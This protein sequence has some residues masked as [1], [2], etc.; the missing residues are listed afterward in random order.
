MKRSTASLFKAGP[1]TSLLRSIVNRNSG[2]GGRKP[3]D[4]R[5]GREVIQLEYAVHEYTIILVKNYL[6][7]TTA[8]QIRELFETHGALARLLVPPGGT[9]AI[10]EFARADEASSAFR[11]VVYRRLRRRGMGMG[12]NR[13]VGHTSAAGLPDEHR[14]KIAEQAAGDEGEDEELPSPLGAETK[15]FFKT[16]IVVTTTERLFGVFVAL[17]SSS[18]PAGGTGYGSVGFK[19][20]EGVKEAVKSMQSVVLDGH[21]LHVKFAG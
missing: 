14:V 11:T 17:P 21:A 12:G 20:V 16:L 1:S 6:Y 2:R 5:Q 10:V 18:A 9:M 7:G 4:D 15:L 8:S 19:D 13:T 3:E